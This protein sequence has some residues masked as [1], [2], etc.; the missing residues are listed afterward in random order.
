EAED[1]GPPAALCDRV[2]RTARGVRAAEHSCSG[3][4]RAL[5]VR[6]APGAA[7]AAS[8]AAVAGVAATAACVDPHAH[9]HLAARAPAPGLPGDT[10]HG[11]A[12]GRA[13]TGSTNCDAA[14]IRSAG[15]GRSR[16]RAVY[17]ELYAGPGA[18]IAPLYAR[19]ADA[20]RQF[21]DAER[22]AGGAT[23]SPRTLSTSGQHD[24]STRGASWSSACHGAGVHRAA[25]GDLGDTGTGRFRRTRHAVVRACAAP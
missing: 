11:G 24:V 1:R 15:D 10:A 9:A 21:C 17:S 12:N 16:G 7:A 13:H 3:G 6:A 5:H 25:P 20:Q 2:S 23:R 18:A 22:P 4:A 8:V 19:L 14:A